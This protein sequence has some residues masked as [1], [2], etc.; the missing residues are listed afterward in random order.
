VKE[1]PRQALMDATNSF[2]E[3]MKLGERGSTIVY[4]G[5]VNGEV[6]AIKKF[7]SDAMGTEE[8]QGFLFEINILLGS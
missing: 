1:L 5:I 6:V 2:D 3:S 7:N 8:L 4:K